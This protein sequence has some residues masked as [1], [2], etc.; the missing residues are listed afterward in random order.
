[1][2]PTS[3][4]NYQI[5]F[6]KNIFA[7]E[8]TVSIPN[9]NHTNQ[10]LYS[11]T[12]LKLRALYPDE[13]ARAIAD[14]L[15]EHYFNFTPVQRVLSRKVPVVEDK[16]TLF[17]QA[18]TKLL[19]QVPLQYV[20]GSAYFMDMEFSVNS[21][22][23][24]PRP[25][26]EE[27]VSMI[28]K[29]CSTAIQDQNLKIMDIGTGSGCIAVS[30]SRNLAGSQVTAVD[31]SQEAIKVAE[32]NAIKNNAEVGFLCVD[33]LDTTQW[34]ALPQADIIVSNPPYVT[35][36]EKLLMLP[37]VFNYEP[38]TALFVPD[39]DPLLFYSAIIAFAKIKL[40]KAG[41][42]WFEINEMFGEELQNMAI[43]QGFRRANIIFDI[44][45]KSRF[46]QCFK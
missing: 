36:S 22:V 15:F 40:R 28:V 14:R 46:L 34:D 31:I 18:L 23:L 44:R 35:E 5:I 4:N 29:Y 2:I 13:E 25:E 45:G 7:I 11:Y 43:N 24:I 8:N 27:L 10:Q 32:S 17:E 38:H 3:F 16:I 6:I 21:S 20:I 37:N 42:L 33:I 26:T 1:M 39:D 19:N 41:S 30:L 12:V 9:M